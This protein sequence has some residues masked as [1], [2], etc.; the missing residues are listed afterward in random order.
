VI[1]KFGFISRS[2]VELNIHKIE[3]IQVDQGIFGRLFNFSSIIVAGAGN[4][5]ATY[6]AS[7]TR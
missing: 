4:P 6:R 7:P 2:T 1:A 3:S 5:Q